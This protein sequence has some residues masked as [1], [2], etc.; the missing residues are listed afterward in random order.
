[1]TD[2]PVDEL[3]ENKWSEATPG[4]NM[5]MLKSAFW[6]H[7]KLDESMYNGTCNTLSQK[8]EY[9]FSILNG[10]CIFQRENNTVS[11]N[12]HVRSR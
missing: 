10:F 11:C 3:Y 9:P 12:K 8:K 1:M 5:I 2:K 4:D 6:G 7:N